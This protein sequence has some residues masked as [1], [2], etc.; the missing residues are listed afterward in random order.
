M[1]IKKE[2]FSSYDYFQ[3]RYPKFPGVKIC[4]D[5]L[6]RSNVKGEYLDAVMWE[7]RDHA[8]AAGTADLVEA[9]RAE[10]DRRVR[11]LV[12]SV[13]ADAPSP[14]DHPFLVETLAGSDE[15]LWLWAAVGL[16]HLDTSEARQALWDARSG[17]F[18]DPAVTARYREMLDHIKDYSK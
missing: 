14:A 17:T 12:L 6:R 1:S 9:F 7:L 2:S 18:A 4:V 11:M 8:V 10:A 5:L 16:H 15:D 3:K 13:I